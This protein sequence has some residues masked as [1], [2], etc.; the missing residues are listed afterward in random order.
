LTGADNLRLVQIGS[1][2]P[3][4]GQDVLAAALALLPRPLQAQLEVVMIGRSLDPAFVARVEPRLAALPFVR[5]LGP[6]PHERIA[7]HIAAADALV[8]PSRDEVFPVTIMEAMSLGKPVI[9]TAVGGIPDMIRDGIDGLLAPPEDALA[10]AAAIEHLAV[11]T[12]ARRRMGV[13]ARDRY[14]ERFTIERFG[15][16]LLALIQALPNAR[17]REGSMATGV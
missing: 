16:R 1:M 17:K 13:S 6:L 3:R 9:A 12:E 14:A 10:L 8:L 4:K 5:H 2:E 7:E 15:E 11:D